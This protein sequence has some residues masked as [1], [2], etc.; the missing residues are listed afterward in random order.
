MLVCLLGCVACVCVRECVRPLYLCD[1]IIRVC[2]CVYVVRPYHRIIVSCISLILSV[3]HSEAK[4]KKNIK[5]FLE[6]Q[7]APSESKVNKDR[8]GKIMYPMCIYM[9][10]LWPL[11]NTHFVTLF[12]PSLLLTLSH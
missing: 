10:A 9:C 5:E 3:S 1:S 11:N 4:P 8:R 12:N 6:R 2:V 7:F